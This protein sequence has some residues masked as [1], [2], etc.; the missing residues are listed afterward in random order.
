M[1]DIDLAMLA[2]GDEAAAHCAEHAP[3][4]LATAALR[5]TISTSPDA[6]S[7]DATTSTKPSTAA[8]VARASHARDAAIPRGKISRSKTRK[9]RSGQCRV[10]VE[11]LVRD[12]ASS[13]SARPQGETLTLAVPTAA[14]S[15]INS[16]R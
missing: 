9:G 2:D 6:A 10:E 1:S 11:E 8:A 3:A 7:A 14:G 4:P 13:G 15:G 16:S 12:S 5:N